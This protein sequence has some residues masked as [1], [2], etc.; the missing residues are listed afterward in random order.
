[1]PWCPKCRRFQD[2]DDLCIYCWVDTVEELEPEMEP[3]PEVYLISVANQNEAN[4][5]RK[6]LEANNILTLQ[7]HRESGGYLEVYMGISSFGIDVFVPES[8]LEKAKELLIGEFEN[9]TVLNESCYK[10]TELL[11]GND[12]EVDSDSDIPYETKRRRIGKLM[13]GI[14]LVPTILGLIITLLIY[15]YTA[16]RQ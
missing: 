15:V 1:M 11:E 10:N 2:E 16:W 14:Y 8:Q 6:L 4:I 7:K 9:T 12:E 3:E 5:I 13:L